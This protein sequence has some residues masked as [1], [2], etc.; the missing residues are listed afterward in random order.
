M[1]NIHKENKLLNDH[2]GSDKIDLQNCFEHEM[3]L[4]L[5]DLLTLLK[6]EN[7]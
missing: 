4:K 1:M 3:I 7:K 2:F 6:C 5:Q